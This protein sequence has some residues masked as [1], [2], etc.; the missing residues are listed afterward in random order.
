MPDFIELVNPGGEPI[1]ESCAL[2]K[3]LSDLAG[4]RIGLRT[5][6]SWKAY[7]VFADRL[8]ELVSNEYPQSEIVLFQN[9]HTTGGR[10]VGSEVS[11]EFLAF[12]KN[13]DAAILGLCA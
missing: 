12:A 10:A 5:D 3:Q 7:D 1:E 11:A 4:K 2:A 13:V 6:S 8:Q 9:T